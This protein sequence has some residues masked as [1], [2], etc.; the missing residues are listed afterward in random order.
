MQKKIRLAV[1]ELAV[2]SF[3]T[4]RM[5]E[6][7]WMEAP[8]ISGAAYTCRTCPTKVNTCCTP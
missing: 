7:E 8:M 4:E 6:R 1:E 2:V 3:E 5:D